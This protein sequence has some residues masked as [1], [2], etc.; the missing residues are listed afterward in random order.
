MTNKEYAKLQEER[1]VAQS[2]CKECFYRDSWAGQ[3]FT[4]FTCKGCKKEVS[5]QNTNTPTYCNDCAKEKN[6]CRRCGLT[7]EVK[8]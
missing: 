3:A 5:H 4:E 7:L 6:I 1:R 2:E 8:V